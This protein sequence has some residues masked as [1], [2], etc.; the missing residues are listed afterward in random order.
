MLSEAIKPLLNNTSIIGYDTKVKNAFNIARKLIKFLNK[1]SGIF[2]F[3]F[4]LLDEIKSK[5]DDKEANQDIT[6]LEQVFFGIPS[7][8]N[9]IHN[10]LRENTE[11][12]TFNYD[13]FKMVYGNINLAIKL[14]AK[15]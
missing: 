6:W 8:K 14:L 3:Y 4:K 12:G 15:L 2:S 9:S 10:E 11:P 7:I 5:I 13:K 1:K